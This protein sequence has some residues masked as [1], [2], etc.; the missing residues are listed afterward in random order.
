M[1]DSLLALRDAS[2]PRRSDVAPGTGSEAAWIDDLRSGALAAFREQGVPTRRLEAWKGT[3]FA[4]LEA[5]RF[6]RLGPDE[7]RA[8]AFSWPGAPER[9]LESAAE[10]VFVDGRFDARG[11]S[12]A[13]LPS[14]CRVASL[15]E[16]VAESPE[17]LRGRLGQLADPKRHALVA[18]QTAFHED[19]AVL[20]IAP[21]TVLPD[22]I[23]LRFL[24]TGGVS[25]V[26]AAAAFPRLL[27]VAGARSQATIYQSFESLDEAPGFTAFVSELHLADA[28][29]I[30]IVEVQDEAEARIHFSSVHAR[31]E[32]DAQ[33]DSH[34]FSLGNGLTRSELELTLA[35]PG[36][37][38]RLRGFFLGRD[39]GHVDHYT[40][41]EHAVPHCTSDQEYRGVLGGRSRG[42]FRG[43]V[44]IRPD[45]QKTDARQ[46]NPNLLVSEHATIDSKPQLEI[47]ADDVRASHGSTIGQLDAD[48][49]LFLRARGIGL[50]DARLLL[51]QAFAGS[52]VDDVSDDRIRAGVATRV[53]EALKHLV[54][55]AG[56]G[57]AKKRASTSTSRRGPEEGGSR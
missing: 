27:V 33:L 41:V 3:S 31:L 51:T 5:M 38:A 45:A 14:G 6:S 25:D 24:S 23:Q 49:L 15:A 47:Y 40:T 7:Q 16:I 46:S 50:A 28:A 30:E 36:A 43:R 20:V 19:G 44:I 37:G 1:L 18:L 34:V 54:V 55:E 4:P 8:A 29:R 39:A 17:L 48:A 42:V 12:L 57:D 11:S 9:S 35:G 52:I 2:G 21:G 22:P 13:G 56:A 32:R 53:E 26:D 10:L